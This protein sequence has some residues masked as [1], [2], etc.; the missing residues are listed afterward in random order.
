MLDPLA[1]LAL[2]GT[3]ALW[4]AISRD[5]YRSGLVAIGFAA[6]MLAAFRHDAATIGIAAVTSL[7]CLVVHHPVIDAPRQP[8]AG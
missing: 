7:L 2:L 4:F 8:K 3:G 1:A 5:F 6:P